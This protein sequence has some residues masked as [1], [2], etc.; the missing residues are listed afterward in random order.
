MALVLIPS[1]SDTPAT[2]ADWYKVNGVLQSIGLGIGGG[3]RVLGSIVPR[4]AVLFFAGAWYV[5]DSDT[6]ITGTASQYVKITNT[7]GVIAPSFVENI[8]GVTWNKTWQGWYDA[9]GN[10]YLFDELSAYGLGLIDAPMSII[11]WRPSNT[12]T[13]KILSQSNAGGWA[14][15][16]A[17]TPVTTG[18][19][20]ALNGTGSST[21]TSEALTPSSRA[22]SS[23]SRQGRLCHRLVAT[24]S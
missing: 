22:L 7:A 11:S 10:M 4:G 5:A 17:Q 1:P 9:D 2:T 24:C 14:S 18:K 19:R 3:T 13:S 20:F 8:T 15:F 21:R 23:T 16:M 6:A 12:E